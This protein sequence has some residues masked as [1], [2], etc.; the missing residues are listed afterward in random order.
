MYRAVTLYSIENG[1]FTGNDIDTEKLK[2][3]IKDIHISFQLNPETGRP[4]TYLNG[5]NVEKKIRTM[6]VSSRVS[7]IAALDFVREAMVARQQA[8]GKAKGIVMDGRDIGTVVFPDAELKIFMTADPRVRA[9]RRYVE[10]RA[11]GDPV[12]LE[13][14]ERNVRERDKA[15]M[16]R[17]ISPLRQAEDAIVLDNSC[18][19]LL[20]TSPSPRDA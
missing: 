2:K 11:K 5:A 12:S 6:E 19:C 16:G 13:E 20:Y 3:Q 15:D 18:I 17:A 4:D 14:I 9:C 7:P 1:I 10:L 8:M